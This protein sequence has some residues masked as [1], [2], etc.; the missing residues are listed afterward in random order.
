MI[1][2]VEARTKERGRERES[3]LTFAAVFCILLRSHYLVT[4]RSTI[5]KSKDVIPTLSKSLWE[6]L[7]Y[8]FVISFHFHLIIITFYIYLQQF[9]SLAAP[10]IRPCATSKQEA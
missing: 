2:I 8:I 6:I 3:V 10:F 5:R 9:I 4:I 1:L 7:F